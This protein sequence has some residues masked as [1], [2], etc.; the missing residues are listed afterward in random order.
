TFISG[1]TGVFY[2]QFGVTLIVAIAISAVNA[3]TLSP[4]LCALFLKQ[5][6]ESHGKKRNFVQRFFK[7]FNN[8]FNAMTVKYGRSFRFLFRHKWVTFL[9]LLACL[10]GVYLSNKLMP[11]GFVPNEDRGFLFGH[12]ELPE[13]A[14]VD[15]VYEFEKQFSEPARKVPGIQFIT[16]ISGRSI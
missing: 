9:I 6:D 7:A 8:A 3:L 16:M 4:A 15:R 11:A 13:G 5:H 10:A 12:L 1:P 14:S 2:K